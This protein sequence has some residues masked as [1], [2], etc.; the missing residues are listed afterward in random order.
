V[1]V[2]VS[3]GNRNI[4]VRN[5]NAA[6]IMMNVTVNVSGGEIYNIGIHNYASSGYTVL[7]NNS[8]IN[9]YGATS[10]GIQTENSSGYP[11]VEVNN[12]VISG[13]THSIFKGSGFDVYIGTSQLRGPISN[14]SGTG[15]TCVFVYNSDYGEIT[16]P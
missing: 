14:S 10:R 16:C 11:S 3:G 1:T 9:A 12:S 2:N 6:P 4:G 8:V 7:V 15:L 13:D 5:N